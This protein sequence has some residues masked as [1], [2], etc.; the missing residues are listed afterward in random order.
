MI[1]FIKEELNLVQVIKIILVIGGFLIV[2][3]KLDI[4]IG[5]L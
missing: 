3:R 4:I 1:K 2:L 5:K